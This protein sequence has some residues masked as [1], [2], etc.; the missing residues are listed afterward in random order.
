MQT[1]N[2]LA[3]QFVLTIRTR[4]AP[5]ANPS[6]AIDGKISMRRLRAIALDG[7]RIG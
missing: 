4:H 7:I 6:A 1:V 2:T 5:L 3:T